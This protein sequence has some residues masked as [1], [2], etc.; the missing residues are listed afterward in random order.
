MSRRQGVVRSLSALCGL[1]CALLGPA[2]LAAEN[3][4]EEIVVTGSYIKRTTQADSVSPITK[5]IGT[6][7]TI[8]VF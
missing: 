1:S 8:R 2:V 5:L 7:L 3:E 6:Q 4:I